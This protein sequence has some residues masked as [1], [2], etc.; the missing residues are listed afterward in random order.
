MVKELPRLLK[1]K[2]DIQNLETEN[3][4]I[5]EGDM[6]HVPT[7][8]EVNYHICSGGVTSGQGQ[9]RGTNHV[10]IKDNSTIHVLFILWLTPS[11][12]RTLSSTRFFEKKCFFCSENPHGLWLTA[13]G[14]QWLRG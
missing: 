5:Y 10:Y 2:L 11:S 7:T 12:T 1:W 8:E 4:Q 9:D 14:A 3:S 6:G 13:K